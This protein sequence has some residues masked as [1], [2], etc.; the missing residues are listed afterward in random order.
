MSAVQDV[1][2]AASTATIVV[3]GDDPACAGAIALLASTG[4]PVVAA[5]VADLADLPEEAI[6]VLTGAGRPLA[7]VRA[8]QSVLD[9]R[10]DLLVVL[11]MPDDTPNAP[12]RRALQAGAVGIVR[13]ADLERAL[14]PTVDAIVSGQMAVPLELGSIIA[15][16]VLSHR[17]KEILGL[18]AEGCT[19]RQIAG[20]LF[21]AE[22]T[23]KTHLSSAFEKLD[24]TSRA[25][26]IEHLREL[27]AATG[28]WKIE[29]T[30][31]V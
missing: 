14:A 17:E 2:L 1:R 7:R 27:Q 26:A 4:R 31:G 16:R 29:P 6:V 9:T 18:V 22:S 11:V 10:S 13:T 19:N 5:G 21:I 20:R 8:L 12:L 24:A 23:V 30:P 28:E 25:E 3:V 15:P